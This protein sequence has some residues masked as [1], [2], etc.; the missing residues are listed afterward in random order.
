MAINRRTFLQS[1]LALPLFFRNSP[2]QEKKESLPGYISLHRSGELKKRADELTRQ[3]SSCCLCPREC[4]ANRMRGKTGDCSAPARTKISSAF[5]HF[6]EEK[7]LIGRHGSGTIFFSHCSLLCIY[8]QNWDISHQGSGYLVS[9]RG[10]ADEMIRLQK[11]GCHNINLVT[12]THFLP[13]IVTALDLAAG[14]GLS[15]P[16]VY[17][18]GGYEKV[19]TL[20][21]LEGII[22]IYM[23]DYKYDDGAYAAKYSAGAADYP[24]KARAAL[25]EM[26]R[27]VGFL[28]I[29]SQGLA[30]SGLLI[31]HLV[32]PENIAGT[33][34][35]VRFVAEEIGTD[36]FINIMGQYRPAY[37]AKKHPELARGLTMAEY[38]KA[39]EEARQ[40]GLRNFL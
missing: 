20:R 11:R 31:R 29:D 3:L 18:T 14:R 17:N 33:A 16:T 24:E 4:A 23:P 6:G 37:Q 39:M 8:C 40:A 1:S 25:L 30:H 32:L 27:Q 26:H 13:T 12:P 5:P 28:K 10:L 7:P 38:R 22:D 2:A 15:I 35:F 34:G 9:P 36:T 19:E 21:L